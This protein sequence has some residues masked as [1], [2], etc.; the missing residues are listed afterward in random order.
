[1]NEARNGRLQRAKRVC[2]RSSLAL[3]GMLSAMLMMSSGCNELAAAVSVPASA[4][5]DDLA[6]RDALPTPSAMKMTRHAAP[7]TSVATEQVSQPT[8]HL[9]STPAPAVQA[10]PSPI[11]AEREVI[12]ARTARQRLIV[13]LAPDHRAPIRARI[14]MG[15]SFEVFELV[16][17]SSCGGKGWADV[18]NG[19]F[20]CLE[21]SR[22]ATRAPRTMPVTRGGDPMP[23]FF[24]KTRKG[25]SARR[26]SSMASYRAGDEPQTITAPGRDFA[27]LGRKHVKGQVM[28]VDKRGRVMPE[29]DLQRFRPSRFEGHDLGTAPVAE[30]QR[31]AWAVH[32][33]ETP[34]YASTTVNPGSG[35]SELHSVLDYHA[36]I[37]VQPEPIEGSSGTFYA[38]VDGGFVSARDI[39]RFE[40]VA[41]LGDET[42]GTDEIWVDVELGQQ[43]L[44]V[45]RGTTPV[46]TTLISSGLK[47]PTPRGLFRIN[48]K[49]AF[50]SMSSAPGASDPYA[51]EAVPYVQ[52]FHGGIALHSAYWHDRFGFRVSHGCVN[53]SPR[54]AAFVYSMTGPHPRDGWIDVYEDEGDMGTRVRVRE[55]DATVSDRRGPVE[56]ING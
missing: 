10:E 46:Y 18:G 33:P 20:V 26:W 8:G 25:E 27:F 42:V 16:Q 23:F 49:Q 41:Q 44:T 53:L 48:K 45:M 28:L 35:A 3:G 34:V 12:E 21:R 29:R 19:G 55:G 15:E 47:G 39:R 32:W 13:R 38:L 50:G 54:D 37:R 7:Q 43:V 40:P 56:H 36:E 52:Y 11:P 14:P 24:A 31:L 1:M 51:V 22:K 2:L 17:G 30:G 5:S 9:S 4:A 6:L